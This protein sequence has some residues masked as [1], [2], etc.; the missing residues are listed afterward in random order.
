LISGVVCAL[1]VILQHK[2]NKKHVNRLHDTIHK[3]SEAISRQSQC[4]QNITTQHLKIQAQHASMQASPMHQAEESGALSD[5]S[6]KA[7]V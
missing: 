4:F 2:S 3:Q 7:A 1:V 6:H 5:P